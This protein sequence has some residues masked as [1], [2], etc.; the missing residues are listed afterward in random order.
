MALS[1]FPERMDKL[2]PEDVG[3]SLATIEAYISYMCERTE[4]SLSNSFK[5]V[6]G[7]GTSSAEIVLLLSALSNELDEVKTLANQTKATVTGLQSTVGG[8]TQSIGALA[9]RVTALET[10]LSGAQDQITALDQRVTALE[11][12]GGE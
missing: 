8:H 9:D 3:R 10:G 11:E 2:D 4:F 6:N 5:T 12:E 1:V 7:L